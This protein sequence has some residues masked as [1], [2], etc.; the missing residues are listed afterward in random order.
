MVVVDTTPRSMLQSAV[1]VVKTSF[2]SPCACAVAGVSAASFCR[3]DSKHVPLSAINS[4]TFSVDSCDDASYVCD[5]NGNGGANGDNRLASPSASSELRLAAAIACEEG[6]ESR[7]QSMDDPRQQQHLG[8]RREGHEDGFSRTDTAAGYGLV[9]EPSALADSCQKRSKGGC[10]RP[11]IA[12]PP[13]ISKILGGAHSDTN[14]RRSG[15]ERSPSDGSGESFIQGEALLSTSGDDS[16]GKNIRHHRAPTTDE[17]YHNSVLTSY[18]SASE[19]TAESVNASTPKNQAEGS[20][21]SRS[22]IR[23]STL[24]VATTAS[25]SASA[26]H[27]KPPEPRSPAVH[28]PFSPGAHSSCTNPSYVSSSSEDDEDDDAFD[29]ESLQGDLYKIAQMQMA[30]GRQH[31]QEEPVHHRPSPDELPRLIADLAIASPA[32][33]AGEGAEH[34]EYTIQGDDSREWLRLDSLSGDG[35]QTHH[36]ASPPAGKYEGDDQERPLAST[37]R[38]FF[39]EQSSSLSLDVIEIVTSPQSESARGGLASLDAILLVSST[40]SDYSDDDI[41]SEN[42]EVVQVSFPEGKILKCA[43]V[44]SDPICKIVDTST[45]EA[46]RPTSSTSLKDR[47]ITLS[48]LSSERAPVS[49]FLDASVLSLDPITTTIEERMRERTHFVKQELEQEYQDRVKGMKRQY[50]TKL[51]RLRRQLDI[52]LEHDL[53]EQMHRAGLDRCIGANNA[54][55][56]SAQNCLRVDTAGADDAVM[57]DETRSLQSTQPSPNLTGETN[58]SKKQRK[59]AMEERLQSLMLRLNTP[60]AGTR[61]AHSRTCASSSLTTETTLLSGA[62]GDD[63]NFDFNCASQTARATLMGITK[64]YETQQNWLLIDLE[65]DAEDK[66]ALLQVEYEMNRQ[67]QAAAVKELESLAVKYHIQ[68]K[69]FKEER[70]E[71]EKGYKVRIA[72]ANAEL[73]QLRDDNEELCAGLNYEVGREE[74]SIKDLSSR[75]EETRE[76]N[77]TLKT[78]I[79]EQT[80]RIDFLRSESIEVQERLKKLTRTLDQQES[81]HQNKLEREK[82]RTNDAIVKVQTGVH[83]AIDKQ[84]E[85]GDKK[86]QALEETQHKVT[87]RLAALQKLLAI[88]E[89]SKA[90][91]SHEWDV[92]ELELTDQ[93]K[94]LEQSTNLTEE[95]KANK[96]VAFARVVSQLNESYESLT[97]TIDASRNDVET[98]QTQAE[99]M[100]GEISQLKRDNEQV[101]SWISELDAV[102]RSMGKDPSRLR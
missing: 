62:T 19:A 29:V 82:D 18:S 74:N 11:P 100:K 90:S 66:A 64:A 60:A 26:P 32:T 5:E 12:K 38:R 37:A 34:K 95:R 58:L 55:Q 76:R 15:L 96:G 8:N 101:S 24:T 9:P 44:D 65:N 59:E 30:M 78:E 49:L 72:E 70:A 54:Q 45:N 75:L 83:R 17:A 81:E 16:Q 2:A 102:L 68:E 6:E 25:A 87:E 22:L 77:A 36:P 47:G 3:P 92:K 94:H 1:E 93:C 91:F 7:D 42:E 23:D 52:Q 73:Q 40:L 98:S 56:A 67:Q 39:G 51:K 79:N 88:T 21:L 63:L 33:S 4:S 13:M 97:R 71:I 57:A 84:F 80:N 10:D 41:L 31:L 28:V 99:E 43:S 20:S 27:D 61:P 14:D 48:D 50:S 69:E 53:Q 86:K 46:T 89:S 35:R 85:E